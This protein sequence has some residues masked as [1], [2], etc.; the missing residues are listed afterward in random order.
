[1]ATIRRPPI[2]HRS[3]QYNAVIGGRRIHT[4]R[5][6]LL[7]QTPALYQAATIKQREKTQPH[8][9]KCLISQTIDRALYPHG[10]TTE[11]MRIDHGRPNIFVTKKR[12]DGSKVGSVFQEVGRERLAKRIRR[13]PFRD[14]RL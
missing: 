1:M 6:R 13:D 2:G 4:A 3:A 11:H 8:K 10:P 9:F 12:L 5:I 7:F 14:F